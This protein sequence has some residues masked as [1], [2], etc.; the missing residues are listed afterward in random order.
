VS[1][2]SRN[3]GDPDISASD[4][5]VYSKWDFPNDTYIYI[6]VSSDYIYIGYENRIL[7]NEVVNWQKENSEQVEI[8]RQEIRKSQI[9]Y[10]ATRASFYHQYYNM[11][12]TDKSDQESSLNELYNEAERLFELTDQQIDDI[13]NNQLYIGM[14]Y[15]LVFLAWGR[16]TERIKTVDIHGEHI[17]Y[18]YEQVYEQGPGK[19]KYAYTDNDFLTSWQE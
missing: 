4:N 10:F 5:N 2:F 1:Y 7:N 13:R 14:H 12:G 3:Y 19:Y 16:P 6:S 17:K 8:M 9:E 15:A 11:P 18:V